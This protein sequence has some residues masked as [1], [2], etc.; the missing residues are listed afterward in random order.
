MAEPPCKCAWGNREIVMLYCRACHAYSVA[1][2][3]DD[4]VNKIML[5]ALREFTRVVNE[6]IEPLKAQIKQEA[7]AD[8]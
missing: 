4:R 3:D 5:A 7:D 6:G 8:A 2:C 1:R